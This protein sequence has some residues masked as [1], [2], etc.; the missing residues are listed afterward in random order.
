[1]DNKSTN[2]GYTR[3]ISKP[4]AWALSYGCIVGWGAFVMPGTT[5]LPMAGPAGTLIGM[6]I[7]AVIITVIGINYHYMMN[8]CP[9]AGGTFT[10]AK[11][12]F[13]YDHGFLSAWF[14]ILAYVSII[15]ANVTALA[16]ICRNL[17]GKA[18]MFGYM[19]SIADY[20]VYLGEVLAELAVMA[21]FGA[22]CMFSNKLTAIL[23]TIFAAALLLGIT[24]GSV[25]ALTNGNSNATCFQP[26][27]A[28][29]SSP[30][31]Q[32]MGI[33]AL[34]PWAF[35]GF[36]SVSN[37][38]EEFKFP[39]KK[40]LAI[41][42]SAIAAGAFSYIML[43]VIA[44][45]SVPEGYSDW[46]AYISALGS[47]DGTEKMPVFFAMNTAGGSTGMVILGIALIS[48]MLTGIL[49]S[50]I[51]SSRL[52]AS[53]AKENIFPKSY[54]EVNGRGIP[55]KAIIFLML[56]SAVIP[57]LGRTAIGWVVDVIT[58]GTTIAYAYTSAA[59][60]VRAKQSGNK[61]IMFCGIAGVVISAMIALLLL[62]PD[63]VAGNSLSAESYLLLAFW[64]IL[65]IV[66]FRMIFV[67][68]RTH[69]T[70]STTVVWL[71][72]LFLIFFTSLMWIRQA[73]KG[74]T[75]KV[76]NNVSSFYTDE[77]SEHGIALNESESDA[78]TSYLTEQMNVIGDSL[79]RNS[80]IQMLLI[81]LSL[82]MI[83]N[84]YKVMNKREKN[85]EAQKI[86]AEE[87]SKAK[88]AFLSNMSHDIRTPMNAII[89]YS[90][91][92]GDPELSAVEMREYI[93]KIE[94]SS[95]YL[96][97]LINDILEMSRIESG[98]MEPDLVPADL[99]KILDGVRDMFNTQMKQKNITFSVSCENLT[100]S[101]VMCDK[102]RF[103]RVLFN[104]V[105][106]SYKFTPD[107]GSVSVRLIQTGHTEDS[108]SYEIRVKD[109]GIGMSADFAEKVFEAFER[110]RT[111]TVSG[112]QGTGLGLAI[113]K[114]I[115]DMMGGK[116]SLVTEPH[117]GTEFLIEI[118]FTVC[119]DK[120]ESENTEKTP[121]GSAVS[122]ADKKTDLTGK[123]ILVVDDIIINR[124]ISAKILKKLG[125]IIETAENGQDA[126]DK[127][128]ECGSDHYDAIL[129]DIQ[130][131]VMD[132]LEATRRIRCLPDK[133]AADI[134]VIA[135]TANAFKEDV[136]KCIDAGMNAHVSKPVDINELINT[137]SEILG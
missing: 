132:G 74:E 120:A 29:G 122:A 50:T 69:K 123:K 13:G 39:M 106:N 114:R 68:D 26:A 94:N 43:S 56:A 23:Q 1:M 66:M 103:D 64:G 54:A 18:L 14:M 77:L 25:I 71:A 134:P 130:M 20:D 51:A 125:C 89:G 76:V 119:E 121:E 37:S 7:G 133:K 129:M 32:I 126:L 57:F 33:T 5:F 22:V 112:I 67:K 75:E 53:M 96:L 4:A 79:T 113:T 136:Q 35:V 41:M 46:A 98:K 135:M 124:E 21:V 45:T 99:R 116:V 8:A 78:E 44:T 104:L 3:Y 109:S 115:V 83:F 81:M 28:S 27:F 128:S 102:N 15:W 55:K 131:P 80:I 137:M 88:S 52:F 59:A 110:E 72:L 92:A 97:S 61:K 6:L 62:V 90:E 118:S 11:D 105:S 85:M 36:E 48:A 65:G 87:S 107:G 17:F 34:A 12:T 73:T 84:I 111:S 31:S 91:L 58:V 93:E 30:L 19:Y 100:N 101:L 47:F 70:G 63:L 108:A 16:L 38:A 42:L 117:K 10:Y 127:V 2:K 95:K 9:D 82:V 24:A 60:F 40:I 86:K 49:G